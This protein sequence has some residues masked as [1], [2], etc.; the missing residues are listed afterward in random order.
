[1]LAGV[2][3]GGLLGATYKGLVDL[4]LDEETA[5]LYQRRLQAGSS[6]VV[7]HPHGIAPDE[8]R[9]ILETHGGVDLRGGEPFIPLV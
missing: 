8:A 7:V 9:D 6:V 2:I 4:G 5:R 3:A 1:M